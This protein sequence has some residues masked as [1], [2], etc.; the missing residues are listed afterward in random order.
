MHLMAW[1]PK[2]P[3]PNDFTTTTRASMW[4]CSVIVAVRRLVH[5]TKDNCSLEKLIEVAA[6]CFL[7]RS[8]CLD[9][10]CTHCS[11]RFFWIAI[12]EEICHTCIINGLKGLWQARTLLLDYVGWHRAWHTGRRRCH[13]HQHL[14]TLSRTNQW[15][16]SSLQISLEIPFQLFFENYYCKSVPVV[17]QAWAQKSLCGSIDFCNERFMMQTAKEQ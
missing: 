5:L 8:G 4:K 2:A 12:P 6:V 16:N 7:V 3:I 9:T 1:P 11:R 13:W 14:D 17:V 10:Q 15:W